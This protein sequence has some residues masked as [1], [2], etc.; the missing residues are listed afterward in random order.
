MWEIKSLKPSEFLSSSD[1]FLDVKAKDYVNKKKDFGINLLF[2][3]Y[4]MLFYLSL[5]QS[6]YTNIYT[7]IIY[8]IYILV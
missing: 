3:L 8:S 6:T 7:Y 2:C 1:F 5:S 4:I